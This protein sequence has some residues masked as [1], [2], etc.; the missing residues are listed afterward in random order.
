MK[1]IPN[2]GNDDIEDK[3]A[4]LFGLVMECP[5]PGDPNPSFCQLHDLRLCPIEEGYRWVEALSDELCVQH[6]IKHRKCYLERAEELG[7]V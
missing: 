2:L 3:K 1:T 6:Y 7:V 4:F 5:L